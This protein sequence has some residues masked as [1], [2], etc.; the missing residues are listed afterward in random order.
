[1]ARFGFT[2]R[3]L[4]YMLVGALAAAAAFGAGGRATD[5]HGAIRAMGRQPFGTLLLFVVGLG[6][7][8]YAAWRVLQ[9][10][11]DLDGKGSDFEGLLARAGFVVSGLV[12]AGLAFST[13]SLAIGLRHG[14]SFGVRAWTTRIMDEPF[15]RWMVAAAGLAVM[16]SGAYQF[17]KA[18]KYK[19]EEDL[20]VARMTAAERRWARRVGRIGLGARGVTFG[21]IG[22]FLLHAA[23]DVDPREARGMKGA[24]RVLER[25]DHGQWLLGAVALGLTAYGVLSL[26][27]A[28]FRKVT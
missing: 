21:I 16:G 9:A 13:F 5:A 2:A 26:V 12:H 1:M 22:W 14:R 8:A 24:L 15:G 7:A 28:R 27:D 25:Q 10:V 19:F 11:L 4:V 23:L 17:Y 3:A 18:W 20:R 6:L